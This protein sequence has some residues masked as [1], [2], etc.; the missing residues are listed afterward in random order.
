MKV[1]ILQCDDVLDKFQTEFGNYPEMIMDMLSNHASQLEYETFDVRKAQ[2]PERLD[3]F[4]FFVITGS[5][6]SV[7]DDECWIKNFIAFI[8]NLYGKD[9]KLLGICFGHQII[10]AALGAKVEKSEKGWGVGV[11]NNSLISTKAW[12]EHDRLELNILVSHQDQVT[13]LP[14]EADVIA[15]SDFCPNFL[16]QW[17]KTTLSVQGHPEW[18]KGYSNAL[19]L[20]RKD[21]IPKEVL[22]KGIGSLSQDLD[23]A[24]FT[25]Y[26]FKFFKIKGV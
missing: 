21:I 10:A 22:S 5:K 25:R 3:D 23:N 13:E 7:Y 11:A 17:N 4:E 24:V 14:E 1:A 16:V 6:A 19:M 8:R 20:H 18:V 2:Y 15:Q 26:L 9:K 12:F